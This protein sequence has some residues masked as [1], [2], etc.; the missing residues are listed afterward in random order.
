[1]SCQTAVGDE[2]VGLAHDTHAEARLVQ[3][4]AYRA[5]LPERR[6]EIAAQLSD[7]I[8]EIARAGIR[9]RHPEYTDSE[10]A[11]ALVKILY[12]SLL[13]RDPNRP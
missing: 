12:G 4:A 9:S 10:V 3:L 5:M 6:G 1:M 7:D 13:G 8:R 2:D 11:R